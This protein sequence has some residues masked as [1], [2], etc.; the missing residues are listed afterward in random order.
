MEV[1]AYVPCYNARKTIRET[2]RS[3]TEQ[4]V[5]ATEI[6]VIDDGSGGM[7]GVKVVQLDSNAGR[8][9]AR[10]RA[11]AEARHELILGCD[12]TL[13]LDR[14]F[15][16]NALTWFGSDRVAAVFGRVNGATSL[17]VADR[18]RERHLFQTS[19][20]LEVRH[21]ASLATGC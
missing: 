15:L 13:V 18:W 11:M 16:E 1:S 7:T 4:T 8:G 21:R 9:A 20:K 17:R 12:A 2:I 6:F 19:L 5:L 14:H 3:I 10:A